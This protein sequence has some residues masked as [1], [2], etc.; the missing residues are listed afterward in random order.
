MMTK[1]IVMMVLMK[2]IAV[3]CELIS[4]VIR[5]FKRLKGRA[6]DN[7]ES[8]RIKFTKEMIVCSN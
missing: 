5:Q 4:N 1:M 7:I 8:C 6:D 2:Q 3:S